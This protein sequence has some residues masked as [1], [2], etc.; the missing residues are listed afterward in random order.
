MSEQIRHVVLGKPGDV[1]LLSNL[2]PLAMDTVDQVREFFRE[3]G[4][5]VAMFE[6]DV[7]LAMLKEHELWMLEGVDHDR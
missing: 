1:L 4:I 7:D 5:R 6:D 2:G 3:L